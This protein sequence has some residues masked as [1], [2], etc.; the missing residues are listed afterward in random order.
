MV[1]SG[2][3]LEPI[4]GLVLGIARSVRGDEDPPSA[5]LAAILVTAFVLALIVALSHRF[6]KA[7][8]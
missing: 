3:L 6:G 2:G 8:D 4:L 7:K 5:F 1:A